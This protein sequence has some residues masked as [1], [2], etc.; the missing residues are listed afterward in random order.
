MVN[1][2]YLR[3]TVIAALCLPVYAVALIGFFMILDIVCGG[4]IILFR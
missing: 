4:D 3:E 1:R 2:E